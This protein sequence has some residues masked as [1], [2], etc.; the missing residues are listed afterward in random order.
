MRIFYKFRL[1]LSVPMFW[2]LAACNNERSIAQSVCQPV[3]GTVK[4]EG[5]VYSIGTSNA[6]P[7]EGPPH[8]VNVQTFW[9]DKTEVSVA[10]FER[11]VEDTGYQTVAEREVDPA[12]FG[13]L[14]MSD[15]DKARFM[16]PGGAVFDPSLST[17]VRQ[18]NWWKYVPGAYWKY[19]QGPEKPAAA[20]DEPVT[21]I[22]LE[23]ALSYAK[24]AG[25][26]LPTEA[27]WEIAAAGDD[28]S[29]NTK[30]DAP[31]NANT[32]QGLF[33][34]QNDET[35]GYE[36]VAPVGCF[37]ANQ[38]GLHDMMG[39]VWEWTQDPYTHQRLPAGSVTQTTLET[40]AQAPPEGTVKGG[41]FLCAPNYCMRY[42][43]SARHAQE[44]GLGTNHIG[45]RLAYDGI[46]DL[47]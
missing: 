45:F 9:I 18:L 43:P 7:E 11:F 34:I 40:L 2:T 38:N 21:Q 13:N 22:A 33:P 28:T 42:R 46:V 24:W 8:T 23:D 20:P 19:P 47:K 39:N 31:E 41:S 29:T 26:R 30:T 44:T 3:N 27:E 5:G 32:W 16:V 35:D 12:A 10:K 1:F 25:G 17:T 37:Q 14:Q 36:G 6:Y 4:I 15:A